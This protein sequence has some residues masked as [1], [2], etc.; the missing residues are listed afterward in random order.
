[1]YQDPP[2]AVGGAG[3][4]GKSGRSSWPRSSWPWMAKLQ[5][6]LWMPVP[7]F[8]KSEGSRLRMTLEQPRSRMIAK[9]PQ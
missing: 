5:W 4:G 7:L 3:V 6:R 8:A 9:N 1:M 2:S